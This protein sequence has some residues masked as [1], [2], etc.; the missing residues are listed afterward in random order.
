MIKPLTIAAAM[1]LLATSVGSADAQG[2]HRWRGHHHNRVIIEQPG[3]GVGVGLAGLLLLGQMMNQPRQPE[4][5]A[6]PL[7]DEPK[8]RRNSPI[9]LK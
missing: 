8:L 2:R 6:Q 4:Q 7:P 9:P 3:L 5:F 1:L